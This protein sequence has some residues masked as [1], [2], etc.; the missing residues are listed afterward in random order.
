MSTRPRAGSRSTTST[1]RPTTG[2]SVT[3]DTV[4]YSPRRGH[5]HRRAVT[6]H[7]LRHRARGRPRNRRR[8][9]PL[10]PARPH[11]ATTRSTATRSPSRT[12]GADDA[13]PARS[14]PTDIDD[15]TITLAGVGN[16]FELGQ[17][18]DL[19]RAGPTTDLVRVVDGDKSGRAP[20]AAIDGTPYVPLIE[21]LEHGGLVLRHGRRRPVQPDRRP[22]PRRRAGIQLGALEN[23]TRGG[24]ARIKLGRPCSPDAH[25][26]LHAQRHPHPRLD[27]P[28]V[29]RR[30]RAECVGHRVGERR[31]CRRRRIDDP[32]KPRASAA[33]TSAK[34]I[35][36]NV[37]SNASWRATAPTAT[38]AAPAPAGRQDPVGGAL[39]FSFTDHNV[40]TL[41]T[42]TADLNSNDDMELTSASSRS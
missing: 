42:S 17:A 9:E 34:S 7:V 27:V 16:T 28:D 40:K 41:I 37:F 2:S 12:P 32:P 25:D 4:D 13:S 30:L 10:R 1:T 6:G 22:A 23:E 29:R 5:E 26:G 8:R 31:A 33:S 18:V 20:N 35:F 3:E 38:P 15:D 39:A 11:R 19:P 14:A 36:D 21:G 24:I